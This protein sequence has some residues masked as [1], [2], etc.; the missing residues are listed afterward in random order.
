MER[1]E[2]SENPTT[3]EGNIQAVPISR[4]GPVPSPSAASNATM[5]LFLFQ[6]SLPLNDKEVQIAKSKLICYQKLTEQ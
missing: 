3:Q 1:S 6:I 4:H 2:E 5:T